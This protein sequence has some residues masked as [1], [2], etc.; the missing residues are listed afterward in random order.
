MRSIKTSVLLM[1]GFALV[2]ISAFMPHTDVW[3][4][5]TDSTGRVVMESDIGAGLRAN[6]L[7]G[8][9]F[10]LGIGFFVW[11]FIRLVRLRISSKT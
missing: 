1:I 10:M 9:L 3:R 5:V 6:W 2:L 7:S 11:C 4:Q 8:V